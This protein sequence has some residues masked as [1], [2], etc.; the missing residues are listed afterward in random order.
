M[1]VQERGEDLQLVRRLWTERG[2]ATLARQHLPAAIDRHERR[3]AEPRAGAKHDPHAGTRRRQ[4][5]ERMRI[6]CGE[7]R[8]R[9]GDRLEIV[10]QPQLGKSEAARQLARPEP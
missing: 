6:M 3:N 8:Q 2:M 9:P 1:L 4:W 10:D 5:P 7:A